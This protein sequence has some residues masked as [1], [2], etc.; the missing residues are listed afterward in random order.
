[1]LTRR[2]T[3]A[4]GLFSW[5][6][7]A[8]AQSP[9]PHC[10]GRPG[11]VAGLIL[12]GTGA[13]AGRVTVFGHA[14]RQG[15]VRSGLGARL[16]DGRALPLQ[17][18]VKVRH[19]DGSVRLAVLAIASP[20]LADGVRA[21]VV[22]HATEDAGTPLDPTALLAGRRAVME[23]GNWRADLLAGFRE[24]L[25]TSPWQ[26]GPLALQARVAMAVPPAAVGGAASMRLVA[27]VALRADGTLWVDTWMRN[28]VAM[29][30]NGG[31]AAYSAR[32]LLD[33]RQA[34]Q[35][36][37]ARHHQYTGWGRMLGSTREAAAS[38][39]PFVRHDAG[40]LADA[41]AVARYGVGTGVDEAVLARLGAAV[42]A[43]GWAQLL[44]SR[45][46]TRD[47]HQ[48]GARADIGPA[49]MAQAVWLITGDRRA[50]LFAQ[51]QAEA[52]GSI[53]WHFWDAAAGTWID[54]RRWPRIWSDPRGGPPPGGLMQ[55]IATDTGW[56]VDSAHQP[57]LSYVPYL[58][59]GRRAFL[60]NLQAQASWSVISQWPSAGARGQSTAPGP[61]E[62]VNVVR[63]NQVRGGAW[64]LRQLENGA[65]ATP[66]NDPNLPWLRMAASGNWSWIASQIPTWTRQQG[67]SHGWIP[68][69]Y[70]VPGALPPWQQDYFASTAA[71]ATRRGDPQARAVLTWM[72]NFLVGRFKNGERGF[73]PHDGAAYLIATSARMPPRSWAELGAATRAA[74]LSNGTGWDKSQGD[75]GQLA[76][77]SLAAISDALD[78]PEARRIR[79][80]LI[81]DGAPF[82][83]PQAFR[84]DPVL[85]I[86]PSGEAGGPCAS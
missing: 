57:D 17:M 41:A 43:P 37:I 61:G 29:R 3:L 14:F 75:Y 15:D 31:E 10:P 40:Y 71:I 76:L 82:T 38:A 54:T 33:G 64:S 78:M 13:P 44:G 20:A 74:N 86:V 80:A 32:L 72:A 7:C 19:A 67:G 52:A 9:P 70:G 60:D 21:A 42:A 46:I 55:P 39:P 58:L 22:L 63:G 77:Q 35:T 28:D 65:W 59:T 85:N 56:N 62:G 83:Q 30:P 84:R 1:M 11:D 2:A 68:G 8:G 18:D 5:S 49:T 50:A 16:A 69:E 36:N 25:R 51:G 73:A 23:V 79:T 24:A 6:A 66:D 53:P 81:R 26:S 45:E 12:E 47:M 4:T 48:T 34:A 27:D